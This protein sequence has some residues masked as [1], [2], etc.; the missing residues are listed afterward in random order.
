MT[1]LSFATSDAS[2]GARLLP[3]EAR[4]LY[5]ALSFCSPTDAT[6]A[7][8]RLLLGAGQAV[9]DDLLE[10][11]GGRHEEPFDI[12]FRADELHV[13]LSALTNAATHFV[14]ADGR[15]DPEAFHIRLGHFRQEFDALALAINNAAYLAY[16][17]GTSGADPGAE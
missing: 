11:L 15:F 3:A 14:R 1:T 9:V 4:V 17:A 2:F 13:L 12:R 7:Y 10:R 16:E 8:L 6:D 5:E